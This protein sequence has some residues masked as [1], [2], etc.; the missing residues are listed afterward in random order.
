[1]KRLRPSVVKSFP[2]PDISP[3][4]FLSLSLMLLVLP[5]NWILCAM[6][7]A[8]IHELFHVIAIYCCRERIRFISLSDMGA[9]I[10][11][12]PLSPFQELICAAAGPLGSFLLLIFH[13][14]APMLALCGLVQGIYNLLPI[15]ESDG[16]RMLHSV[17]MLL[18]F[19][20]PD[21][22]MYAV[23]FVTVLILILGVVC[24]TVSFSCWILGGLVICSLLQKISCKERVMG[25]Q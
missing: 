24:I 19:N 18:G 5:L 20:H 1:M 16:W 25:L 8:F 3:V 22:F 10:R 13:Q 21:R 2:I 4:S 12:G 9:V 14:N 7:A 6:L 23:Q 15:C 11:T 17:L